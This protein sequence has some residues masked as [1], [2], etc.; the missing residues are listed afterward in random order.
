MPE[1]KEIN[2][3]CV[4]FIVNYPQPVSTDPAD[5]LSLGKRLAPGFEPVPSRISGGIHY[6]MIGNDSI[7]LSHVDP[8]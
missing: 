8:Q 3:L 5:I 4:V 7:P 2:V 1:K 6:G